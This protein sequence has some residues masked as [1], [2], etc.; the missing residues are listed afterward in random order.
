MAEELEL[1]RYEEKLFTNG[2]RFVDT[3]QFDVQVPY[4]QR[5]QVVGFLGRL[6][7]EK[8]VPKLAAAAAQLPDDIRF[9]FVGDGDYRELLEQELSEEI[10]AGSVDVVGWVNRE[11]VPAQ[12]NRLRLLVLPSEPTEGLPTAILEAM[13]CGT[14]AYATP[15]AGVPDVVRESETGFLMESVDDETIA[16][17]IEKILTRAD[18]NEISKNARSLVEERYSFSGA[19][20]RY[21]S[22]LTEISADE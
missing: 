16:R 12:L 1:E 6:D 10:E 19:V 2:A 15:V 11:A 22:I 5:E 17:E 13:G 21:R 3:D 18:L 20:N 14:P 9:V 4:E 8:R 7:V